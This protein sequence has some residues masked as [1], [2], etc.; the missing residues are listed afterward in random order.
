M[1]RELSFDY[2]GFT[3][4]GDGTQWY[5]VISCPFTL[6]QHK[7]L[8]RQLFI[9]DE[10]SK[11]EFATKYYLIRDDRPQYA[12]SITHSHTQAH[13]STHLTHSASCKHSVS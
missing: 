1:S 7:M 10:T 4:E 11:T 6:I 9:R 2:V 8:P 13:T 12:N 3:N 5:A